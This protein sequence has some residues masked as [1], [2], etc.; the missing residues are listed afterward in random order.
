MTNTK[1]MAVTQ[2]IA[3]TNSYMLPQGAR[4]TARPLVT[5]ATRCAAT[6]TTASARAACTQRP[7]WPMAR[8]TGTAASGI[9]SGGGAAAGGDAAADGP[10][11]ALSAAPSAPAAPTVA[12]AAAR[13]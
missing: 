12:R 3:V 13:S 1:K 6:A 8:R 11:A 5:T 4:S 7:A 2:V 10:A 9:E